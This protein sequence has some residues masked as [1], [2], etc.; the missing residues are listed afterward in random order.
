MF[1]YFLKIE[2]EEVKRPTASPPPPTE[3]PGVPKKGTSFCL[4]FP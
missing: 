2:T 4:M 3:K 1:E